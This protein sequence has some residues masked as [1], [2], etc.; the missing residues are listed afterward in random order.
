MSPSPV[1]RRAR[2]AIMVA[3][4]TNGALPATLLARYAEVKEFLG[5][6]DAA[7]GVLIA[8]YMIGSACSFHLPGV[9][10]RRFGM[11]ATASFG[12]VWIAVTITAAAVGVATGQPWLFAVGMALCGLGD[13]VVDVAQNAQGLR[14][15]AAYGRSLLNSMHGGWSIGAATGGAVG[16]LAAT[17]GVPLVA[18]IAV[19]ALLC[20]ASM[21]LSAIRFLPDIQ[22]APDEE[23]PHGRIGRAALWHLAPL[24][25]VALAGMSVED[26]GNNWSA[27]LLSSER[28][29]PAASAGIGL[30]IMLGAQ[31]IGRMTGDRFI[32][33]VGRRAALITSLVLVFIGLLGT[34]WAPTAWLTIAALALAGLG[35]AITIPLAFSVADEIPG[36]PPHSGVTAVGWL[37]RVATVLLAPTV[38]GIAAL[39]SL[40]VAI[41]CI[42]CISLVALVTQLRP[43][44]G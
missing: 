40:S 15:Q 43:Q 34:A 41:T 29:M 39:S 11:R 44:R 19:W 31:F 9:I 32:D 28:G 3:F 17:L 2:V 14:V 24:G 10:L 4:A 33:A 36:I 23:R 13:A 21:T 8:S 37:M 30:S 20:V 35:C 22:G 16:A 7:F 1:E 38:G 18:H 27:V 6:G 26:I 5:L 25:L 12:T 42:A